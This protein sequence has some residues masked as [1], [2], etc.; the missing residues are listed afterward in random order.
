MIGAK[1]ETEVSTLHWNRAQRNAPCTFDEMRG[2]S[3]IL[4]SEAEVA[5]VKLPH[6][7]QGK[8]IPARVLLRAPETDQAGADEE[9]VHGARVQE[10]Q[11]DRA[12]GKWIPPVSVA[13]LKIEHPEMQQ[14]QAVTASTRYLKKVK[15]RATGRYRNTV[16]SQSDSAEQAAGALSLTEAK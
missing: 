3:C 10:R 14:W 11:C 8:H 2:R 6:H 7:I 5:F 15:R 16:V 12:W 4:Q 1:L 13:E 9:N